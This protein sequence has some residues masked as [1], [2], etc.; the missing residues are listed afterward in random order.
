MIE[1]LIE[2]NDRFLE[3]YKNDLTMMVRHQAINNILKTENAFMHLDIELVYAILRDLKVDEKD[4][5]AV[6]L[7]LID[8]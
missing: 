8:I 6:Y 1:T 5:K 2:I 7:E 3:L 4:L